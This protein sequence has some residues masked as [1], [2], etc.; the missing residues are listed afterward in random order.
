MRRNGKQLAMFGLL[1][2][3]LLG[4]SGC[5]LVDKLKARDQ[6]NKG[7]IAYKSKRYDEAIKYFEEA[8][9]LDL[10]PTLLEVIRPGAEPIGAMVA[11]RLESRP[12]HVVR[13]SGRQRLC[14]FATCR[15]CAR[16]PV[17]SRHPR[18]PSPRRPPAPAVR[19]TDPSR[20]PA[21]AS[22]VHGFAARPAWCRSGPPSPAARA[23]DRTWSGGS[24]T[25]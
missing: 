21:N 24:M 17:P 7:T 3:L 20:V 4:S 11:P 10:L 22:P 16:L 6:L 9:R 14:R 15:V 2:L 5:Q 19:P 12:W 25:R 13:T 23:M 8:I 18:L 1:G